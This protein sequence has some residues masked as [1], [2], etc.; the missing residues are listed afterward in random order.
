MHTLDWADVPYHR[1]LLALIAF[2]KWSF[3]RPVM[4]QVDLLPC[5]V[6][7]IILYKR[8]ITTGITSRTLMMFCRIFD[9]IIGSR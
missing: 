9:K 3:D 4:W 2:I 6:I 7:K 5:I 1:Q 8:K